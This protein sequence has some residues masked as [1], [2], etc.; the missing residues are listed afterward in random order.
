LKHPPACGLRS[1]GGLNPGQQP[2]QS[3]QV[4]LVVA[5][6]V[7]HQAKH[8][9]FAT[10]ELRGARELAGRQIR[11]EFDGSCARLAQGTED[12]RGIG[13][14]VAALPGESLPVKAD[15]CWSG[16]VLLNAAGTSA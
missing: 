1:D 15:Q 14:R 16:F 10:L 4:L 3:G 2:L 7:V 13:G 12:F 8:G 6:Q 11:D 5:A 9:N